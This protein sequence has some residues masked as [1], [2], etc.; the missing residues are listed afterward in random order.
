M[1]AT[2]GNTGEQNS[3]CKERNLEDNNT[4]TNS[5]DSNDEKPNPKQS[6]H[7]GA[8]GCH[9]VGGVT[10]KSNE[11]LRP[12]RPRKGSAIGAVTPEREKRQAAVDSI[13]A[14][15]GAERLS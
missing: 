3:L 8:Q 9:Q 12:S 2:D 10:S 13:D 11:N 4:A 1:C 14:L 6:L 5:T 7:E 15:I